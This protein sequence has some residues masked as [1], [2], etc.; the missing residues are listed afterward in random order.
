MAK[1]AFIGMGEAGSAIVSGWGAEDHDISAFDIKQDNPE[2]ASEMAARYADLGIASGPLSEVIAGADLIFSPVT[3][4]QAMFAAQA[5]APHISQGAYFCD[6]NSCAPSSKTHSAQVVEAHGGRYVD[7]AVL[8]PVHPPRNMVPMLISGPH[9][10]DIEPLLQSLPMKPRMVEG[11][12]GRASTIKMVRSVLIKGLEALTAEFM[13][14]VEAADVAD[15]VLPSLALNYPGF[16]WEGQIAYNFERAM[17]H[18]VRRAA[19]MEEV[20]K[21]LTDLGLPNRTTQATVKW[22]SALAAVDVQAPD[23]PREVGPHQIA[24]DLLPYFQK[25]CT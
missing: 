10:A 15:E 3:A 18:G 5:A 16:D 11:A 20:C 21:T 23:D 7:V 25:N 4:D 24:K 1:I 22:E 14:A 6:L 17:V 19:E 2:H 13:L 8:S 12:V 9:A